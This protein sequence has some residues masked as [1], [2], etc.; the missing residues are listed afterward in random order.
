MAKT[1]LTPIDLAKNELQNAAIQNLAS[2][3]STPVEGQIYYNTSDNAIYFYDGTVWQDMLGGVVSVNTKTGV[4]VLTPDDLDDTATTNKFVTA[5]DL[6]NLS[7]LSGTNTG[8][9][10]TATEILAGIAEIATQAEVDAGTADSQFITPLKLENSSQL[11]AKQDISEKGIANGYAGLDGTGKVPSAQLPSYVD[12]VEEYADLASFPATGETG[13]IYV[14]L[15]TNKIYRWSGSVYVEI[16]A[17]A[18]APVTSVNTKIGAVVLNPDDLDDAGSVNKFVTAADLVNLSNLSGV[19]SGD[20]VDATTAIRGIIELATQ[21]EANAGVDAVRAITPATLA[22]ALSNAGVTSKYVESA[23]VIG[24]AAGIQTI[25]HNLNTRAVVVSV[26]DTTTF[27]Q[28]E[29]EVIHATLNTI[30]VEATGVAKT[31]DVTIIG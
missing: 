17:D 24:T 26:M 12:D 1:F 3:P 7:N 30:T 15:D 10:V 11:A 16:S 13:K 14:A 8:D 19:N 22:G 4:V 6:I 21:I 31:V 5:A 27:E 28:Y 29:V 20:E 25:T 2:A 18:G 9:E 23:L